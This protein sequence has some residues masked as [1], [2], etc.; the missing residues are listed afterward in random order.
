VDLPA[1]KA[2]P[3]LKPTSKAKKAAKA[4][5]PGRA[6]KASAPSAGSW[7]KQV[8]VENFSGSGLSSGWG[9]YSGSIPSMPGGRW[10]PSHVEV[11]DGKLRL[12]TS[13]VNGQWTSGGVMNSVQARTTYGKYLVRFRMDKAPGV[14]YAL[15]LWP[16]SGE[17][18]MDGEIDFAEDGGGSRGS[19]SGT[20][21]WGTTSNHQ[22][23]Q[24]RVSANFSNWHTVGV[25]WTPSKLVYTLDG[26]AWGTVKSPYAPTKPMN[27]ALQTEA[28]SCNTW[29]TCV[30]SST[31]QTTA[32]EVDWV[33]VYRPK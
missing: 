20:M 12:L 31:P 24:R 3:A 15:L 28:G 30:N 1:W 14:K 23:V 29:M 25:E 8:Y 11:A 16:A 32:L 27:L 22:Q 18:P 13:K 19:T 17:W 7:W 2:P 21:H 5:A 4:K 6:T 26:K 33:A 9:A 10:D